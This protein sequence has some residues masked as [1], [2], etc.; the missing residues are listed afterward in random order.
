MNGEEFYR[1][2]SVSIISVS[3][4]VSVLTVFSITHCFYLVREKCSAAGLCRLEET[5]LIDGLS[6]FFLRFLLIILLL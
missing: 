6:I 5:S 3:I 2:V 4:S 1:T